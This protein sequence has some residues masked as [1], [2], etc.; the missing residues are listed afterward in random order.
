MNGLWFGVRDVVGHHRDKPLPYSYSHHVTLRPQ[1]HN[2]HV[3]QFEKVWRPESRDLWDGAQCRPT[4]G[5][6]QKSRRTD[7]PASQPVRAGFRAILR[8]P[9]AAPEGSRP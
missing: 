9:E 7:S 4:F 5:K 1:F 8:R 3:L 2:Q 6:T